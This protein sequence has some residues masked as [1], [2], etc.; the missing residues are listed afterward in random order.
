LN[1]IIERF[2][3]LLIGI[4]NCKQTLVANSLLSK[5][6]IDEQK[7]KQT[8]TIILLALLTA[9]ALNSSNDLKGTWL[10][11][12]VM[13]NGQDVTTEHDPYDERFIILGKDSTFESGGRPFGKNTGKFVFNPGDQTLFLDSDAGPDDDSQWKVTI[14]GDTMHW[15]GYGSEWAVNFELIH[16]RKK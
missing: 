14:R 7:M 3:A 4:K 12:K 16:T 8:S 1:L 9:C 10:M 11:H 15:I 6:K 13:L 2:P 5:I